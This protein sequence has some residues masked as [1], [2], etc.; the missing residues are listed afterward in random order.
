[1]VRGARTTR[2]SLGDVPLKT[3]LDLLV[4]GGY[5]GYACLEWEKRWIPSLAE[6]EIVFPQYVQKMRE[7]RHA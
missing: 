5:N 6:P 3:M 7:A 2:A 4:A 1:M